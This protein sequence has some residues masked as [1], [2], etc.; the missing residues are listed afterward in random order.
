MFPSYAEPFVRRDTNESA[1]SP[2]RIH[3]GTQR[4]ISGS[5]MRVLSEL[6][7]FPDR[8]VARDHPE[9]A[10]PTPGRSGPGACPVHLIR[11]LNQTT[12]C[13]NIRTNR[14]PPMIY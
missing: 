9:P 4:T 3:I 1:P 7:R 12:Y 13:E 11:Y 5:S 8:D 10:A 6:F 2:P 14:S